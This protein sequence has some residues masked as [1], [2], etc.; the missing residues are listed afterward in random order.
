[1]A[2]KEEKQVNGIHHGKG[3]EEPLPLLPDAKFYATW[4][5]E[6]KNFKEPLVIGRKRTGSVQ[7][8]G[9]LGSRR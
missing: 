8:S 6:Q 4:D 5:Y 3:K 1:V 7:T 2:K 9:P